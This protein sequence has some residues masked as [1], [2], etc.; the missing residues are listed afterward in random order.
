M[1]TLSMYILKQ[2]VMF[3]P[4]WLRYRVITSDGRRVLGLL[5]SL[6]CTYSRSYI[7]WTILGTSAALGLLCIKFE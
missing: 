6:A 4:V 1:L 2:L 5:T 7:L 3:M